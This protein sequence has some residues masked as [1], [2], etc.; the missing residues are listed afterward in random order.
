[1]KTT[2]YSCDWCKKPMPQTR[3][4][5]LQAKP[6]ELLSSYRIKGEIC[7]SCCAELERWIA[8]RGD[9]GG[10]G[11]NVRAGPNSPVPGRSASSLDSA[12]DLLDEVAR[13]IPEDKARE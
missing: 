1:M 8:S 3:M 13:I 7:D 4:L 2:S 11:L 12:R 9:N 10:E 5:E 6:V